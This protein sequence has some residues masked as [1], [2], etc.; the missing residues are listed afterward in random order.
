MNSNFFVVYEDSVDD[1][2]LI[3]LSTSF[4]TANEFKERYEDNHL[5]RV[6]NVQIL[7]YPVEEYLGDDTIYF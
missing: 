6:C 5:A 3:G 7:E 2:I 1:R 4:N